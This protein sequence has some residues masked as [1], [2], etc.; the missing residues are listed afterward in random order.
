MQN[1]AFPYFQRLLGPYSI[2][3]QVIFLSIVILGLS[4][5]GLSLW[6]WDRVTE[7]TSLA[8]MLIYGLRADLIISGML[9]SPL[10]L[11][12]PFLSNRQGWRLWKYLI[13]VWAIICFFLLIFMELATPT[14]IAEYDL[15][16][17]RLFIEYLQYPSEV[18]AMLW[19][20][21]RWPL[22]I[23]VSLTL[24]LT[25]WSAKKT[26]HWLQG[27]QPQWSVLK[28]IIV[29]PLVL[30]L[31]VVLIRSSFTHRPANPALF[32]RTADPMVNSLYINSTWSVYFALYNLKHE[33]KSSAQ[34]GEMSEQAITDNI[35]KLYPWLHP[36]YQ[37]SIPTLHRQQA[38]IYREKPLNLVIVL[39]E[40]LGAEFVASLGG[41]ALTPHLEELKD[42]GWWFEQLYATGTRSVRGIE[43][44]ITGFPPTP[45]RSVVK[46]SLAQ[47]NF[48]TLA[49]LLKQFN[50]HT[51]FVYGGESHFDNMASFFIGNG[52]DS[53]IDERDFKK[54]VFMG[55]WGASDGDLFNKAHERITELHKSNKPFLS[56]I[57][58]SSNHSPYEYPDGVIAPVDTEKNTRNNAVLYSDHALGQFIEQA[59]NSPYWKDTVFL[60]VADHTSHAGGDSLVPIKDFHIPGL[61]LGADIEAKSVSTIASQIDLAPTLL[62]LIGVS[63]SH[64]M[65]G[66]DLTVPE[67]FQAPGR[68]LM[69]FSDNFALLQ[70]DNVTILQPGHAAV[71]GLYDNKTALLSLGG[72][73]D[74]E[75]QATALAHSLLPAWLYSKQKYHNVDVTPL[76]NRH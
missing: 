25:F 49:S 3:F 50:Y 2:I 67:Q 66:R 19:N 12:A 9:F 10:V 7:V 23:G 46:L 48:F 68:A 62:S 76:L 64:P 8:T 54:P 28:T 70:G 63:S 39:E 11:I 71:T 61:I 74:K 24:A 17:N 29:W 43:A 31:F 55:S 18:S 34:Y 15:R 33:T 57:F 52:F 5:I 36:D 32:A 35:A 69:Q 37:A 47:Q 65:I 75:Q 30:L 6:Q 42:D 72:E 58:S 4:R 56:F 26:Q 22:I 60:I 51:E 73:A 13:F 59:K 27:Y 44:V 45:A 40:S 53:V 16:P 14:F 38:S 20:G 1:H 41:E 21:F